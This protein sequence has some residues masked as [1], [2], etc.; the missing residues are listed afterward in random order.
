MQLAITE[1]LLGGG[2]A[3]GDRGA[4]FDVPLLVDFPGVH[5]LAVEQDDGV[6]RWP[7]VR[8]GRD[9]L[10][11]LP[12]DAALV[13]LGLGGVARMEGF[14]LPDGIADNGERQARKNAT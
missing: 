8:A 5:V 11:L 2:P 14:K 7:A 1:G 6:G 10:R 12:D 3:L 9:H 13:D 4:A